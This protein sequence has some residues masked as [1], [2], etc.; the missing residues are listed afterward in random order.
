MDY[1]KIISYADILE[2]YEYE[3]RPA[4][5]GGNGRAIKA[6]D[7]SEDIS[8]SRQDDEPQEESPKIREERNIKRAVMAF[9]RLVRANLRFAENPILVTL[10]YSENQ[11]DWQA[12]KRDF[13]AFARNL[14]YAFGSQVRYICVSEFQ[15]RGA[16]HFHAL[17]WGVPACV[18]RA[19]RDTRMVAGLWGKG[20]V[21]LKETDGHAKLSSYL[22]KYFSKA[23]GDPR[24]F[25]KKL[26]ICSRNV[27][28][29]IV[30]KGALLSVYF[31]LSTYR[32]LY[33][34]EFMT[35]YLGKGRYRRLQEIIVPT[36]ENH[37]DQQA[38]DNE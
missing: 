34:S 23:M 6:R 20:F 14:K 26:Y 11:T 37:L 31:H 32:P 10:T 17:V 8:D 19:E 33:K 21:F 1:C 7:D 16:I 22:V 27:L 30:D 4:N 2:V 38:R 28:K 3:K 15:K 13:N 18:V 5:L 36:Y 24:L 29:P 35:P 25:G 12:S 9:R